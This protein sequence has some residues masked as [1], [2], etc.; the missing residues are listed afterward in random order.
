MAILEAKN[1]SKKFGSFIAVNNIS[2]NLKEGE[3]LGLLGPNEA[4]R[5]F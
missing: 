4:D 2:F 5:W 1:L 3:I